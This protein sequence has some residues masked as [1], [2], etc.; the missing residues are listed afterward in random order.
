MDAYVYA[1]PALDGAPWY[2]AN[3]PQSADAIGFFIEEW[4]GLDNRHVERKVAARHLR[5]TARRAGATE[6]VMKLNLIAFARRS[7][8]W[9]TCSV[10][11][12][13]P[14][15]RCAVVCDVVDVDPAVCPTTRDLWD[16]VA[17]LREVGLVEGVDVGVRH[18]GREPLL[19]PAD[20]VHARRRRPV[21]VRPG[22]V[23]GLVPA[24]TRT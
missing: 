15:R 24:T 9:S 19:H 5:W 21:H 13:R 10:G 6:R 12:R 7:G 23:R 11:W 22:R 17:E 3:Y 8:R 20:V 14:C 4:T 18:H 1:T 2:N 16:G